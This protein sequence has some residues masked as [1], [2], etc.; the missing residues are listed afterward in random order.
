M[1]KLTWNESQLFPGGPEEGEGGKRGE[2][3]IL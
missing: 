1:Q 3:L 2:G